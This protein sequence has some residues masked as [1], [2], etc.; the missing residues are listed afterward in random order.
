VVIRR[1]IY[2]YKGVRIRKDIFGTNHPIFWRQHREVL[3]KFGIKWVRDWSLKWKDFEV[4]KESPTI[5]ELKKEGF[6][7]LALIPFPYR[8][9]RWKYPPEYEWHNYIK[10]ILKYNGKFTNYWQILNEPLTY[11]ALPSAKGYSA[12]DY[13]NL[14]NKTYHIFK[15][16]NP[17]FRILAGFASP[18]WSRKDLYLK[19]VWEPKKLV[20]STLNMLVNLRKY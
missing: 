3:L 14:L 12:N 13:I 7:I 6:K 16:S 10:N 20:S 2:G 1:I 11:Y 9:P 17:K 15:R 19:F 5:K 18:I 4:N 8:N